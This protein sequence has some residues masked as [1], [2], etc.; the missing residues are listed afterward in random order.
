MQLFLCGVRSLAC[1]TEAFFDHSHLYL[2]KIVLI[3][4]KDKLDTIVK[5]IENLEA[6]A[7]KK[8]GLTDRA[9]DSE[10]VFHKRTKSCGSAL[11]S[12]HSQ[13]NH[14]CKPNVKVVTNAA[15]YARIEVLALEPIKK[16][17]EI[18][19]DYVGFS[20]QE[21]EDSAGFSKRQQVIKER[22][23]FSC[24]CRKCKEGI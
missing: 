13:M 9:E 1:H 15:P 20:L 3:R 19:I 21:G 2:S 18:C 24:Q 22:Y 5:Y 8:M 16:G 6:L 23:S 14:S 4:P 11:F 17:D 10:M 12:L 7:A